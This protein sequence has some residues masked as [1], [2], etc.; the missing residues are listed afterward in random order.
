MTLGNELLSRKRP[1]I[2]IFSQIFHDVQRELIVSLNASKKGSALS[3]AIAS[4]VQFIPEDVAK[5]TDAL[6]KIIS[7]AFVKGKNASQSLQR[8]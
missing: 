6:R 2:E 5:T 7:Q 8:I 3:L 4:A 1:Y